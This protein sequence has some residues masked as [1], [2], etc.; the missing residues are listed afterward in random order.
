VRAGLPPGK[1]YKYSIAN[2]AGEHD[3]EIIIERS[4]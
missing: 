1:S 4:K 3:P 2:A